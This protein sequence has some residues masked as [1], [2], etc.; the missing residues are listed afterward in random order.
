MADSKS[1][2][3][4]GLILGAVTAVVMLVAGAIVHAHVDGRLHLDDAP[5]QIAV[6]P[7][8]PHAH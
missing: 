3:I 4:D 1:L 5:Q 7:A 2:W 6:M 8:S